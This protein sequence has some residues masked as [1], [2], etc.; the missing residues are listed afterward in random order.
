MVYGKG[1]DIKIYIVIEKGSRVNI[2]EINEIV[3]S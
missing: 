1:I 2:Y 3:V